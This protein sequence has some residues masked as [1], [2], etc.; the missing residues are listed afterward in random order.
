M[1]KLKYEVVRN[2]AFQQALA[3]LLH[4][5]KFSHDTKKTVA[6][7][8]KRMHEAGEEAQHR[9]AAVVKAHAYLDDKGEILPN[10]GVAGTFKI[11][12]EKFADFQKAVEAMEEETFSVGVHHLFEEQLDGV[13]ISP[14]ELILLEPILDSYTKVPATQLHL[15][16]APAQV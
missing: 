15:A 2:Q 3:K 8:V 13:E 10:E 12:P 16:E 14:N 1:I 11:I 6:K 7:I 9:F 4:Y 5:P